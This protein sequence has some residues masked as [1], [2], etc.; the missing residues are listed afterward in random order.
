MSTSTQSEDP[1]LCNLCNLYLCMYEN[2]VIKK[3]QH[4]FYI[5]IFI[6]D[7]WLLH[8]ILNSIV[9]QL[10]YMVGLYWDRHAVPTFMQCGQYQQEYIDIKLHTKGM[11]TSTSQA[12]YTFPLNEERRTLFDCSFTKF[13]MKYRKINVT[14]KLLIFFS[15]IFSYFLK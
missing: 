5:N 13:K 11:V 2:V 6:K 7:F 12:Y 1:H 10:M 14:M 15:L 8:S 9:L 4:F 3:Q